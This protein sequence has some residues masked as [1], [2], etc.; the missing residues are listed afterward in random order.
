MSDAI[1]QRDAIDAFLTEVRAEI[2]RAQAKFPANRLATIALGEEFGELCKALL[3]E[4]PTR[5]RAEAVQV[6][7]M[8]FRVGFE[9]DA[10]ME[11]NSHRL[12]HG[13]G[14]IVSADG[15]VTP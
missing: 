6:A 9:G 11:L 10:D 4:S 14:S 15:R 8:A 13:L 5:I 3:D 2:L 7:C 1:K 12:R